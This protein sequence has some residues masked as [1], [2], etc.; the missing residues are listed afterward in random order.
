MNLAQV[1]AGLDITLVLT[2][3]LGGIL[4][5]RLYNRRLNLPPNLIYHKFTTGT[6]FLLIILLS[7]L[8]TGGAIGPWERWVG[9]IC[10]WGVFCLCVRLGTGKRNPKTKF[11]LEQEIRELEKLKAEQDRQL[12]LLQ[13]YRG[14]D[15]ADK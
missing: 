8:A 5:G 11:H 9:F 6:G 1:F 3:V 2:A 4:W 12:A 10:L 7:R 15:P 13:N 14:G